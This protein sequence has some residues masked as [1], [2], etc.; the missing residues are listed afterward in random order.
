MLPCIM[1]TK[2]PEPIPDN[3][4]SLAPEFPDFALSVDGMDVY[5]VVPAKRG[6][7]AGEQYRLTAHRHPR[8][9]RY[10]VCMN[11]TQGKRKRVSFEALQRLVTNRISRPH[12]SKE[13][14]KEDSG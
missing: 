13:A 12:A 8:G 9:L 5:R 2:A 11:P 7:R 3:L 6:R 14:N 10:Y 4:I 1:D